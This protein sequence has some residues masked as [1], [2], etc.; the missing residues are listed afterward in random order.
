M[1][2]AGATNVTFVSQ[3]F[4]YV[5]DM[6]LTRPAFTAGGVEVTSMSAGTQGAIALTLDSAA[7]LS[8][9]A[10]FTSGLV[11]VPATSSD[12]LTLGLDDVGALVMGPHWDAFGTGQ[13]CTDGTTT[14][15]DPTVSFDGVLAACT[16]DPTGAPPD[17]LAFRVDS[18]PG[19]YSLTCGTVPVS[20][21][22]NPPFASVGD[23]ISSLIA[24]R[25]SGLKGQARAAC[26]HSQ[27]SVCQATFHG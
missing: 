5:L 4:M 27:Q 22:V 19:A 6:T 11:P 20:L 7:G 18:P 14:S 15:C 1:A 25:C 10:G 8:V 16:G 3:E 9:G 2:P 17:G 23:C 12:T 21:T 26:N 13:L 24:E